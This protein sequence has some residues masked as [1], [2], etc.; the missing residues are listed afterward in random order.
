ML[1]E[2]RQ[3]KI[4][5]KLNRAQKCSILGPQNLGS[6][7]AGPLGLPPGSATDDSKT[8]LSIISLKLHAYALHHSQS[9]CTFVSV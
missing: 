5:D 3:N 7:G 4:M 6:R 2:L 9:H 8:K 1:S